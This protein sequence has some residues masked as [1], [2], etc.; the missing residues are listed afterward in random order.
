MVSVLYTMGISK[1]RNTACFLIY[2]QVNIDIKIHLYLVLCI[3]S[4]TLQY[5]NIENYFQHTC[6]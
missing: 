1:F 3:I 2:V 6:I 5:A 4:H